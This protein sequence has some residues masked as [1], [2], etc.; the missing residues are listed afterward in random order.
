MLTFSTLLAFSSDI[1]LDIRI[2][3]H[4]DTEVSVPHVYLQLVLNFKHLSQP[5]RHSLFYYLACR[6]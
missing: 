4:F 1:I 5:R 6:D 3:L 2:L